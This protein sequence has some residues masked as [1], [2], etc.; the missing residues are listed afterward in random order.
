[1]DA[2]DL[3]GAELGIIVDA[4]SLRGAIISTAQL[5]HLAPMLA[6]TLGITVT[7]A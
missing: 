7:D 2:T 6:E 1:M 5:V 3:R 4:T